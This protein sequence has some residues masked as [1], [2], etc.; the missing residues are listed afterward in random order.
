MERWLLKIPVIP[1]TLVFMFVMLRWGHERGALTG[2]W[3]LLAV[4][5]LVVG[6]RCDRLNRLVD[7][8]QGWSP[9][10]ET[11]VEQR[12]SDRGVWPQER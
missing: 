3:A 9:P 10:P 6:A 4:L 11:T 5:A 7:R 1:L 12:A 8:Q 2:L